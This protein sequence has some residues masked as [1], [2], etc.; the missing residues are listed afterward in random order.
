MANAFANPII[1]NAA[2]K[3]ADWRNPGKVSPFGMEIAAPQRL[4]DEHNIWFHSPSRFGA[5][6]APQWFRDKLREHDENLEMVWNFTIERWVLWV[7]TPRLQN[8][9]SQGW[10]L[11]FI[12]AGPKKEYWPLDERV[13]ARL[14]T[15]DMRAQNT[16]GLQHFDRVMSETAREKE[17]SKDQTSA[18]NLDIAMESFEHSKIRVGYG[19][20]NGSKFSTY[21]A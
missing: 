18:E 8:A 6:F 21:H 14:Y 3:R 1:A 20:S 15:I 19:K 11:L 7:R 5:K 13:F 16:T 9:Y 12:H 2:R 10:T 17:K 4:G